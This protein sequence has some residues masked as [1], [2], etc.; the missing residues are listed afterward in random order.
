[1]KA[2]EKIAVRAGLE[3]IDEVVLFYSELLAEE[4]AEIAESAY[5][6]GLPAANIIRRH[7]NI[8]EPKKHKEN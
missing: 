1:M 6:V 3:N 7:F 4:C 2:F 8:P 5:E